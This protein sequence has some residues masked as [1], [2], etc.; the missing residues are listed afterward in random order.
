MIGAGPAGLT[1]AKQALQAGH[2]VTVYEKLGSVGGIWNPQSNGAYPSVRMQSSRMSFPFTDFAPAV[3]SDFPSLREVH[4]YLMAYARHFEILPHIRFQ[5]EVTRVFKPDSSWRVLVDGDGAAMEDSFDAVMI[6]TGELWTPLVPEDIQR[7]ATP[8]WTPKTYTGPEPFRGGRVLVIGGGVSGA[9]I[10]AELAAADVEVDWSIRTPA[11]FLPR[12]S[13]AVYNDDLFSYVTR[14]AVQELSFC[15]LI[16]LLEGILPHYMA[17]YRRSGL[18]PAEGFQNAVHVNEHI[19]PAVAS[20]KVRV[21]RAFEKVVGP[22]SVRFADGSEAAYDQIIC[23]LGYEDADYSFVDKFD[24]SELYEHF[25]YWRDPTLAVINTPLGT[26]AFGTACPYFE[27]IAEW[28]L[29]IYSGQIQLPSNSE[30]Q[31]WCTRHADRRHRKRFYDCWLETIRLKLNSGSIPSPEA[32]FDT[33]WRIVSSRVAPSLLE[34]L[35]GTAIPAAYDHLFDLGQLKVRVLASLP[36][37]ARSALHQSGRITQQEFDEAARVEPKRR[38]APHLPY[39]ME[40][41]GAE[42][43]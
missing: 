37:P 6:A 25:I 20:G 21:R 34:G 33:Y 5:S 16:D 23:C 35:C 2:R 32:E 15:Q 43:L 31:D 12:Q 18:L 42:T 4:D 40:R 39:R 38:L 1:S 8:V 24:Y 17:E 27:A 28:V 29:G 41:S 10:A 13:G 9:D 14:V 26:D 36:E 3:Q 11:L 7:S 22:N 19:V 30:M